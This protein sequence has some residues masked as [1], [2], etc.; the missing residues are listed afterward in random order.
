MIRGRELHG[1]DP[2]NPFLNSDQVDAA[3][4]AH[5]RVD[6]P[7]DATPPDTEDVASLLQGIQNS[8]ADPLPLNPDGVVVL[9]LTRMA[10]SSRLREHLR[11]MLAPCCKHVEEAGCALE[12]EFA[13]GA[14]FFIPLTQE[15][16]AEAQLELSCDHVIIL[17]SDVE[18]FKAAIREFNCQGKRRPGVDS[19]HPGPPA[20]SS[21]TMSATHEE[22]PG[23]GEGP[24]EV[25][26]VGIFTIRTDSG[27]GYPEAAYA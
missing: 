3:P 10:R 15:H 14:Q 11:M 12:P 18:R 22:D 24:I 9:R 20:A 2:S 7:T 25:E 5:Q 1:Q 16:I 4:V 6:M 19:V 21:S 17:N 8:K 23:E 27:L 26:P 13:E